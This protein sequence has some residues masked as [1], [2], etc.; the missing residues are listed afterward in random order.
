MIGERLAEIRKDHGEKQGELAEAL[1]VSL[2]AVRSWE[3]GKST[4]SYE[5][6]AAICRRYQVSADYLL[7]LSDDDPAYTYNHLMQRFTRDEVRAMQNFA[8]Y[9][10]WRRSRQK[11]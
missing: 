2:S 3:Q 6:L 5:T 8:E 4:P 9:L 7:G 11:R 10:L 1:C